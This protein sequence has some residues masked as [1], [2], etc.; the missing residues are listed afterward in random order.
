MSEVTPVCSE[1]LE[2]LEERPD[3]LWSEAAQ[4]LY[5]S[6]AGLVF[7]GYPRHDEAMIQATMREEHEW[8]GTAVH[9][10]RDRD[11][12]RRS[13]PVAVD[14]VN[15]ASEY[16]TTAHGRPRAID[17]GSGSGWGS[18]LLAEAGYDVWL[19]DFEANSLAIGAIYDHPNVQGRFVTDARFVP[20]GPGSFDLVLMKEFVHHVE[21]FPALFVEANRVLR[22]GGV[23]AL[24]EPTR[25]LRQHV[26]ELRHPDPHHG[27]HITW[28]GAYRRALGKAGF[29]VE[30]ET[31]SYH[32]ACQRAR[33]P[34]V[35]RANEI[36]ARQVQGMAPMS[37]FAKLQVRLLG[38]ASSVLIARKS[39]TPPAR[40]RPEM[41]V[42]DPETLVAADAARKAFQDFPAILREAAL[43]LRSV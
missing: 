21:D 18:W 10:D 19:C 40:K 28:L 34:A 16:V 13:A 25:S 4:R 43:R 36:A 35:R 33:N 38:N 2:P 14:L 15:R 27:H 6:R 31:A 23:L 5:P 9:A 41:N 42:I 37:R 8:Q 20:F 32:N 26:Y 17:L 7:M 22:P 30:L 3:G 12:L 1:T 24:M 39:L 29:R 11:F